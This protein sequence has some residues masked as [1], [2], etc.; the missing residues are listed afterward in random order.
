MDWQTHCHEYVYSKRLDHPGCRSLSVLNPG[1]DHLEGQ[2]PFGKTD[3]LC[4]VLLGLVAS[5]P[6][7]IAWGQE[8]D[9]LRQNVQICPCSPVLRLVGTHTHLTHDSHLLALAEILLAALSK[10][11]P[12]GDLEEVGNV[13]AVRVL[14]TAVDGD[15]KICYV[16]PVVRCTARWI[17]REVTDDS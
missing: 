12:C 9:I 7:L 5:L 8:L 10:L 4:F 3:G 6:V 17:V 15:G 13:V 16:L 2:I 11:S 1:W 14:L